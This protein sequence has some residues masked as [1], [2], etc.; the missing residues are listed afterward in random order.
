VAF[1]PTIARGLALSLNTIQNFFFTLIIAISMP[2][3]INSCNS[4]LFNGFQKK[5][6]FTA[7]KI[8]AVS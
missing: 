7:I 4:S 3:T 5:V 8:Y 1:R 2:R 6:N